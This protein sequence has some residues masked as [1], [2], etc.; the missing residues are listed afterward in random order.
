MDQGDAAPL[1]WPTPARETLWQR[2]RAPLVVLTLLGIGGGVR[3]WQDRQDARRPDPCNASRSAA[4]NYEKQ[5]LAITPSPV[6]SPA[7]EPTDPDQALLARLEQD[8]LGARA[9]QAA[10]AA[11]RDVLRRYVAVI[12]QNAACFSATERAE[13]E[14]LRG[15]LDP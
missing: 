6:P 7:P 2:W 4:L 15:K 8:R 1:A 3:V 13:A 14:V 12:G 5:A 9:S 10:H 11:A